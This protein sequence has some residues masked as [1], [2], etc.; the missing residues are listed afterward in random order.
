MSPFLSVHYTYVVEGSFPLQIIQDGNTPLIMASQNGH[1]ITVDVLLRN[2][3][4]P[5]I[6]RN[7][8]IDNY[9]TYIFDR[10][11]SITYS[12]QLFTRTVS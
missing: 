11:L 9:S 5:N 1:T 8:S 4:D 10:Y 7:V 3:A 6:A 12:E 2:G